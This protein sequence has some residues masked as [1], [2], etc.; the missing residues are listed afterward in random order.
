MFTIR[1][2]DDR[3]QA[4]LGWL[5]SRHSFSFA[6]YQDPAHMNF[7]PLRV[8]NEDWI[9]P[10]TGFGMH[11]HRDMEIITYVLEGAITHRDSM[12]NS[13]VIRAGSVQKMSAGT[14]V[15]HSE[16]NRESGIT[17]H[18][19]QIWITPDRLAIEP[20][21]QECLIDDGSRR[22]RLALIASGSTEEGVV[23]ICQDVR[24]WAGRFDGAEQERRTLDAGRRVYVHVARGALHV[25]GR[26]LGA[27]DAAMLIDE[28]ELTLES[29]S[30]AEVLVFDLP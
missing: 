30:A 6:S 2:S 3:G 8:I 14:G 29:G 26:P 19:L 16:H 25:N 15:M 10:G 22:G 28:P 7:G 21:Y 24:L 5:K 12:G 20:G 9:A 23:H 1:R 17:T 18:M 27:G 11:G 4:D 13:S